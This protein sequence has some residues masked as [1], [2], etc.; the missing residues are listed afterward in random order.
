MASGSPRAWW[1]G[2]YTMCSSSPLGAP[3]SVR[4]EPGAWSGLFSSGAPCFSVEM[5][6][7]QHTPP[8]L[9]GGWDVPYAQSSQS[10]HYTSAVSQS[11]S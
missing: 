4:K 11:V 10:V 8:G 1:G 5:G 6:S 9:L 3:H 2:G 7:T